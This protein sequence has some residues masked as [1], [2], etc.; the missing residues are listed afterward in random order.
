MN[1]HPHY[2]RTV[3]K[4]KGQLRVLIPPTYYV[5]LGHRSSSEE[6]KLTEQRKLVKHLWHSEQFDLTKTLEV[7]VITVVH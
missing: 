7:S 1:T 6:G 5:I 4:S 3:E 2:T